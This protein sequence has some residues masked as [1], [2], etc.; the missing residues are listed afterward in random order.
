MS[1]VKID[2]KGWQ[3]LVIILL[4]IGFVTVRF[5]TFSDM[6]N[7]TTLMEAL[8]VQLMSEYYPD[9]ADKMKSALASGDSEEISKAAESV[10]STRLHIDAVKTSSPLF[11]FSTT[12]DVVVKVTYSLT[13]AAETVGP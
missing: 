9:L 2:F 7:D 6:R 1:Q 4:I 5:I 3:A 12:K 11:N 10:T 8:E 13:D